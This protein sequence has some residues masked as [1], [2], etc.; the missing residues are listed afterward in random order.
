MFRAMIAFVDITHSIP[1]YAVPALVMRHA[2][3]GGK[4]YFE[5]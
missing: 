1:Q 3:L 4:I 2:A 5:F